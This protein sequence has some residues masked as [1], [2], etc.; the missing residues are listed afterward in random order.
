MRHIALP[1]FSYLLR[2]RRLLYLF[3]IL[4][5]VAIFWNYSPLLVVG[6]SR[7]FDSESSRLWA[8]GGFF[9]FCL[10]LALLV[11][12]RRKRQAN[13][14]VESLGEQAKNALASGEMEVE[15]LADRFTQAISL[16]KEEAKSRGKLG[17]FKR[18]DYL[19]DLPWYMFIGAPGAGKTTALLNS[20]L[21][22]P[23][24]EKMGNSPIKGVSGTRNCDWWF[25]EQAVLLDTAGRYTLQTSN[26][27]TDAKAWEG[28]LD[29]VKKYRPKRPVN[30]VMLTLNV[31]DILAMSPRERAEHASKLKVRLGELTSKFSIEIPVYLLVTKM[32]L[33]AG[34]TEFFD[35]FGQ[36]ARDQ[37][38]GFTYPLDDQDA[39]D[40]LKT[41]VAQYSLLERR[42]RDRLIS[43]IESERDPRR[44][45]SIY[46]FPQQF[47]SIKGLLGG[48]VEQIFGKGGYF[49][50]PVKFRGVYFTSATQQGTPFDRVLG[51][52]NQSLGIQLPGVNPSGSTGKSFF[53]ARLMRE[54]VFVEQG[55]AG[56]GKDFLRRKLWVRLGVAAS[57][58]ALAGLASILMINS[59]FLNGNYLDQVAEKV[60]GLGTTLEQ[61]SKNASPELKAPVPLLSQVRSVAYTGFP[62]NAPP[63]GMT[64]GLYQGMK[65][66]G[67]AVVA[68]NRLLDQVYLPRLALR[69]TQLLKAS[70]ADDLEYAY[71]ALKIYLMLYNNAHLNREEM[72]AWIVFDLEKMTGNVLSQEVR[73][74]I[75]KH[76]EGL[77]KKGPLETKVGYDPDLVNAVRSILLP[78]SLE[79][80]IYNRIKRS[81]KATD[82]VDL[83][84]IRA[85]GPNASQVF[86]FAGQGA[87]PPVIRGFFTNNGY[88][89]VFLERLDDSVSQLVPEESWVLG[90]SP[91][92]I[93]GDGFEDEVAAR[94]T[95]L[96]LEDF[97]KAYESWLTTLNLAPSNNLEQSI[98][99][100]R[101]LA[102]VDS[103]LGALLRTISQETALK[104]PNKEG[105]RSLVDKAIEEKKEE[106]LDIIE[107]GLSNTLERSREE[108]IDPEELVRDRFADIRRMVTG[109]PSPMDEVNKLINEHY[110]YLLSLDSSLKV[111]SGRTVENPSE[112]IRSES[113]KFPEPVRSILLQLIDSSASSGRMAQRT[114]LSSELTPLT[115][116]CER[117]IRGRFPF[118]P[119]GKMD[120]L[121]DDFN[122]LFAP[123]KGLDDFF[124][125]KLAANVNKGNPSWTFNGT[126][127][128]LGSAGLES[129][130]KASLIRD[131]FFK[132]GT[133]LAQFK[134]EARITGMD[135]QLSQVSLTYDGT[136]L[137]ATQA[138]S[139][140]VNW[141]WPGNRQNGL[142]RIDY[143]T[144]TGAEQT[145]VMEGPWSIYRLLSQSQMQAGVAPEKTVALVSL[146]NRRFRLELRT[147]SVA[148]PFRSIDFQGFQC[149]T[150]L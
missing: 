143:V 72:Q 82:L 123:D 88:R 75:A 22:F 128:D 137:N 41:Y 31:Q 130:R 3:C 48:F 121:M 46:A 62:L 81:V 14:L 97:T 103:P 136:I 118:N 19:Y 25:T 147:N 148:N 96:Y 99:Q 102:A 104:D 36:E 114:V 55:L 9:G 76:L 47:S 64:Y 85:A 70:N 37:V 109:Q 2:S 6:E 34:F 105:S 83:S 78:Y 87:S 119:R 79:Q 138:G 54:V 142:L 126:G 43:K 150:G 89:K 30:G 90:V 53:L 11:W 100:A 67:G 141:T 125:R 12:Y 134:F 93:R 69:L 112:R 45:V 94:A 44:R 124:N 132:T 111:R 50:T 23:L 51:A 40:I 145:L 4:I 28:F 91:D 24:A 13:R 92:V 73:D 86:E 58:V 33:L 66:D 56:P 101:I 18:V 16:L 71:Q 80:R 110:L 65:M 113:A 29:L 95:R 21:Y 116:L 139:N 84:L 131:G 63:V 26:A 127:N 120:V 77:L 27:E 10:L 5:A 61:F 15:E 106:L 115:E 144:G 117:T 60:K 17:F 149:P 68:Y 52:M 133:G 122:A 42:I 129:F 108:A 146:D 35:D 39:D 20:G 1:R 135:T 32:D 140:V 7:P 107:P 49:E 74:G 38:W 57:S 98:R 59:Y 8:L